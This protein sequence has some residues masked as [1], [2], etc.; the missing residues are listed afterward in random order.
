MVPFQEREKTQEV[1]ASGKS[2]NQLVKEYGLSS[3]LFRLR[4]DTSSLLVGKTIIDLDVRRKYGLNILEVAPWRYFIK[5]DFLKTNYTKTWPEPD[6]VMQEQDVLYV[7]GEV[8]SVEQFCRRLPV[9]N[10]GR[11]YYRRGGKGQ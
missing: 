3:N 11:A 5:T 1:N 8:E 9:G 2:L 10:A 7:T 4:A 6:T